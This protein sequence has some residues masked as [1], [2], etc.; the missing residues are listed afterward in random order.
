MLEAGHQDFVLHNISPPLVDHDIALLLEENL[1]QIREDFGLEASW[2]GDEAIKNLVRSA[3]GLF[4]WAATACRFIREGKRFAPQRL[5]TIL[6]GS[7]S[8]VIAPEKY[9][10]EI[11][12]TVLKHSISSDYTKEEKEELF[13]MLRHTLGSVVVLFTPLSPSSLSRLHHFPETKVKQ[14]LEDLH[15]ILDVPEDQTH[16]LRLHHPSFRDFLL[17]PQRCRDPHFWVDEKNAHKALANHCIQLMSQE[18]NHKDLCG[19]RDPGARVTQVPHK[20]L[21]R[22]LPPELQY[23]CEYWVS[24]LWRSKVE[25]DESRVHRLLR[26]FCVPCF[27]QCREYLKDDTPAHRFTLNHWLHWLGAFALGWVIILFRRL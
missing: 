22:C 14:T 2:P 26:E 18:L 8:S 10:N 15:A 17:S 25:L 19:L 6:K 24:H 21:A 11:Y 13:A 1:R 7:S 9:L 23:A 27:Q 16:L 20:E 3:S 5:D 12:I 4:I